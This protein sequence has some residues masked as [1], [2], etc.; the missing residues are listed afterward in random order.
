MLASAQR[1]IRARTERLSS[2]PEAERAG[3]AAK[4]AE[5]EEALGKITREVEE[6][7][8]EIDK[9]VLGVEDEEDL[10]GDAHDDSPEGA[11]PD[12]GSKEVRKG[13]EKA[14]VE[15]SKEP[16]GARKEEGRKTEVDHEAR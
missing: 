14:K 12:E 15:E 13:S 9:F 8:Q 2:V 5:A 1:R 11:G 6:K 16:E 3:Q 4:L 10:E 7:Y